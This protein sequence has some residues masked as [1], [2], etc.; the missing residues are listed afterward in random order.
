MR[1]GL[2]LTEGFSLMSYASFIEP[3]RAANVLTDRE[4]YRWTHLSWGAS[5][6][7]ASNGVTLI[8]DAVAPHMIDCDMLFVFAAGNPA[9]FD[10]QACFAW[11]RSLARHGVS[12]GGVS[13]GPYLLA[14]AGLL[15]G[16]RATIHWEHAA[17][18]KD[19]FP[20]LALESGLYTIDGDRLTCAGGTASFDLALAIIERGH[21]VA[22][23][24]KVAEWFVGV[25]QRGPD[26]AQRANLAERYGTTNPRLIAMLSA[27]EDALEEPLPR[28]DLAARTGISLR[29][30]ER[31]C[32]THLGEGVAET[33]LAVRLERAAELLR[34]SA[35]PVSEVGLLCGFRSAAHFTRRFRQRFGVPPS[36]VRPRAPYGGASPQ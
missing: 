21:G 14:R 18:L 20:Q 31:L 29:H 25:G 26:I 9:A 27:M 36:Q 4:L 33:Y 23:R 5:G 30:L 35:F 22:L 8:V 11:L 32:A 28:T 19:E 24:R 17:S 2:L 7:R 13:G 12:I 6:A 34:S 10:D 1:I 3:F 15:G 16:R